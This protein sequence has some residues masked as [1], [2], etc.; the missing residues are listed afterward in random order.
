MN[1]LTTKNT[2]SKL[3][4][5]KNFNFQTFISPIMRG[6]SVLLIM[7]TTR[8]D[9]SLLNIHLCMQGT[10]LNLVVILVKEK[11]RSQFYFPC[12][13]VMINH[14]WPF[15]TWWLT[16]VINHPCSTY[17]SVTSVVEFCGRASTGAWFYQKN[18]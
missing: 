10:Y 4:D 2:K 14:V 7:I 13:K 15:V 1:F 3:H 18:Q 6:P 5:P 11:N 8:K 9:C 16:R 17:N 12:C